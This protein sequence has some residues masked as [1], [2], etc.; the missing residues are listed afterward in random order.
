[1]HKD[2]D[3]IVLLLTVRIKKIAQKRW[4]HTK[5]KISP[6]EPGISIVFIINH[7]EMSL[8]SNAHILQKVVPLLLDTIF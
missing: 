7:Q 6:R 5:L 3:K 4:R 1:M 8:E 2:K